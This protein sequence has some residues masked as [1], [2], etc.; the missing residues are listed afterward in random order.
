MVSK[1]NPKEEFMVLMTIKDKGEVSL[2]EMQN[3]IKEHWNVNIDSESINRY[4]RRWKKRK[5]A[6]AN[7]I[8]GEWVY[9]LRD[10]PWYPEAQMIHVVKPDT[11]DSEAK[12]FLDNYNDELKERGS[13]SKRLPNIRD[14]KSVTVT[15]ETLD[16]IA[17][18]LPSDKE[19]GVLTFPR[20]NGNI[21]IPRNWIKGFHRWNARLI[22]VNEN[23]A[24]DRMAFSSGEFA[25]QPKT[26][27][28]SQISKNGPVTYETVPP[29]AKFTFTVRFPTHGCDVQL[30][31]ELKRMYKECELAPLRG[32]GA[33]DSAFG[34]RIK[35][36]DWKEHN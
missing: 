12:A 10:I 1:L 7:L 26:E 9:S 3:Y 33:Y 6:A 25:T 11:A 19:E 24:K 8:S 13:V 28:K 4:A 31:T 15:F 20:H 14:Y 23:F 27:K 18:G 22:N 34:G 32:L 36:V 16:Y 30:E 29:G 35:L 5:V 21:Y 17:G 2:S